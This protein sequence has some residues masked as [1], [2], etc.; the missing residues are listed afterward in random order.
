MR[1][2]MWNSYNIEFIW[3][4]VPNYWGR[5]QTTR[6]CVGREDWFDLSMAIA[7]ALGPT[8]KLPGRPHQLHEPEHKH[9]FVKLNAEDNCMQR[10]MPSIVSSSQDGLLP[11]TEASEGS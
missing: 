6:T 10:L 1:L 2:Y 9:Q 7:V 8:S 4:H 5:M 11:V 3:S